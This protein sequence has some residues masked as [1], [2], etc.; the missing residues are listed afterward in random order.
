MKRLLRELYK[1]N[2]RMSMKKSKDNDGLEVKFKKKGTSYTYKFYS[3]EFFYKTDEE[4]EN[5]ILGFLQEFLE[6]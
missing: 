2:I 1:N 6:G 4:I 3:E 5:I